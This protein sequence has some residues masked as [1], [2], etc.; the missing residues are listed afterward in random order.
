MFRVISHNGPKVIMV[1]T[2]GFHLPYTDH[3]VEGSWAFDAYGRLA[4]RLDPIG[5]LLSDHAEWYAGEF[6]ATYLTQQEPYAEQPTSYRMVA[7][8]RP[9]TYTYR[10]H[11]DTRYYGNPY[12]QALELLR[13]GNFSSLYEL[14]PCN[15]K[16]TIHVHPYG[17]IMEGAVSDRWADLRTGTVTLSDNVTGSE[18]FNCELITDTASEIFYVSNDLNYNE[19]KPLLNFV[20]KIKIPKYLQ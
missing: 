1:G 6:S 3:F 10:G 5:H 20:L 4:S 11:E 12:S 18:V 16:N 19:L 2:S 14:P 7:G 17:T 8:L 9:D 15:E 13:D